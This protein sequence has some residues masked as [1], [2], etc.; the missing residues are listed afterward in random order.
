MVTGNN[1]ISPNQT[2][3]NPF[4]FPRC[5]HVC[6]LLYHL[7]SSFYAVSVTPYL[8][9]Q[10]DPRLDLAK[11]TKTSLDDKGLCCPWNITRALRRKSEGLLRLYQQ[12]LKHAPRPA[13]DR[14]ASVPEK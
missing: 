10:M 13:I 5:P 8:Y 2:G 11:R 4:N 3:T 12:G 6:V 1:D 7:S 9:T 14:H